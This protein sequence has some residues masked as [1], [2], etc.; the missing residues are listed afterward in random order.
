MNAPLKW[1]GGKHYLAKKIVAL[2]PPHIHY[3]EPHFGGGAVLFARDPERD[4]LHG[5][6]S[7]TKSA[8]RLVAGERG[9]SEVVNDIDGDLT[10]FWDILKSPAL[11]GEFQE[12][13]RMTPLSEKEYQRASRDFWGD[14]KFNRAIGFFIRYRQSRQGLGEDFATLSR[15][16]TRRGMN[17]QASAW[18]SAIEGLPEAHERLRR[19]V[20]LNQDAIGVICKQ[21]GLRTLFYCDPPYLQSTRTV[22][23]AYRYEMTEADHE[24]LLRTLGKIKG[25]FQLSGY[26]NSLYEYHAGRNGWQRVDFDLP[27]NAAG[28]KKKRRMVESLWMNYEPTRIQ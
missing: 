8:G 18:L 24:V 16:R 28:G 12:R 19:V 10:N 7:E 6:E 27:N 3:V 14:T 4:W 25:K 5:H 22:K 21:D 2:M 26:L 1:H 11:F 9:C 20:I 13:L 17:E 15:N 23:E